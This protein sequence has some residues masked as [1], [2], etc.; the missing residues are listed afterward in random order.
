MCQNSIDTVN[1]IECALNEIKSPLNVASSDLWSIMCLSSMA[2]Q[3]HNSLS[4]EKNEF[5]TT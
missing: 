2:T 4:L 5:K 1:S 3:S